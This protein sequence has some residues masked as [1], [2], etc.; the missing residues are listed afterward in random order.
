MPGIGII[1]N[2]HSKMNKRKPQTAKLLGYILGHHG[3]LEITQS[4]DEL[5]LVAENFRDNNIEILAINGGDGT[6]SRTL[7]EV[8]R[9]YGDQPL[10]KVALL[11][12]GTMNVLANNLGIKGSPEKLLY[13][14]CEEFSAAEFQ[15]KTQRLSTLSIEGRYGFLFADGSAYNLLAEFYKNKSGPVGA[16]WLG[17]RTAIS[18]LFNGSLFRRLIRGEHKVLKPQGHQPISHTSLT[19]LAATVEKLPFRFRMFPQARRVLR[20]FQFVTVSAAADKILWQLPRLL[21]RTSEGL[22][23][24]KISYTTESLRVHSETIYHYTI[25]GELFTAKSKDL[26]IKVGPELEFLVR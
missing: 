22:S 4:L 8:I 17:I 19:L 1:T 7:T 12:G 6:I 24:G 25:D 3:R 16:A 5:A 14:L 13:R 9:A 15:F 26:V 2:P 18:Y 11:R 20:E 23:K 10:P 21:L